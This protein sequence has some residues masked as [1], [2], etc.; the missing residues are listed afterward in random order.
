MSNDNKLAVATE[1]PPYPVSVLYLIYGI[2]GDGAISYEIDN[3]AVA[4]FWCGQQFDLGGKH[5]YTGFA[6][7]TR[8]KYGNDDEDTFPGPDESVSLSQATFVLTDPGSERPW[9][10]FHAQRYVGAFG[11]YERADAVDEKREPQQHVLDNGH[12]L[13]ALP[14]SSFGNGVTSAGFALFTFDPNKNELG[15][16]EAWVYRGTVAAG[17]DNEASSDEEGVVPHVSSVG[18]LRF[19][20]LTGEPMPAVQIALSGTAIA[21]PGRARMLDASDVVLYAYDQA[22]GQYL[23]T[24]GA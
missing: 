1:A 5:Y 16:Y 22:S 15:G 6:Y 7:A 18:T 23:P 21:G 13:L 10:V 4:S 17:E 19:Q 2:D 9:T 24:T 8:G 11:S 20:P 14:T 3:G 12:L